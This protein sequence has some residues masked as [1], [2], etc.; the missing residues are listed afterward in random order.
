MFPMKGT[1]SLT[2]VQLSRSLATFMLVIIS[3]LTFNLKTG[4][5]M[6]VC[7]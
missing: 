7:Y 3:Y 5:E 1:E 2:N 6:G 4:G